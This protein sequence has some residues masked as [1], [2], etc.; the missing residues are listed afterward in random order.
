MIQL[1][2]RPAQH[3]RWI[4]WIGF[5]IVLWRQGLLIWIAWIDVEIPMPL[6]IL[7]LF[8]LA[9]ALLIAQLVRPTV[10]GWMLVVLLFVFETLQPVT[11]LFSAVLYP[12]SEHFLRTW[13][14]DPILIYLP[15]FLVQFGVELVIEMV[16][17]WGLYR[18]R[19]WRVTRRRHSERRT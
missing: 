18:Y 5:L 6:F 16:L 2:E 11:I 17:L 10:L 3:A 9:I 14:W 4:Y 19:P 15:L 13:L 7:V 1:L 8:V 12:P